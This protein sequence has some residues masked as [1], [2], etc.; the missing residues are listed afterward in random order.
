MMIR[1]NSGFKVEY[2]QGRDACYVIKSAPDYHSIPRLV[3]QMKKQMA[4]RNEMRLPSNVR[5]PFAEQRSHDTWAISR[6]HGVNIFDLAHS[7]RKLAFQQVLG[8]V[9]RYVVQGQLV[10]VM[11]KVFRDKCAVVAATCSKNHRGMNAQ[12]AAEAQKLVATV[13]DRLAAKRSRMLLGPCHGDLTFGNMLWDGEGFLWVFDFLDTFL[14]SPLMDLVKLRQD[15]LCRWTW[16]HMGSK[17]D[18]PPALHETLD[19]ELMLYV[20]RRSW[21]RDWFPEMSA[22]NLARVFQYSTNEAELH[23][24]MARAKGELCLTF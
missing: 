20:S 9:G 12:L 15:T 10:N 6:I 21:A 19:M 23:F 13:S 18:V 14:E 4:Q 24:L 17:E 8:L 1:G 7:E 22:L 5:I 11:P 2:G 16:G 3:R